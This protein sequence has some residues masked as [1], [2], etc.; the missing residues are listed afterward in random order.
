M[1]TRQK[2]FV[3][4]ILMG[5]AILCL[6]GCGT[7]SPPPLRDRQ[8]AFDAS[9]PPQYP[10]QSSGF[11]GWITNERGETTGGIL[12]SGAVDRY[13]RLVKVYRLQLQEATGVLVGPGDGVQPFVDQYG[14]N[15]FRMDSQHLTY[16]VRLNRWA[17]EGRAEDSIWQKVRSAVP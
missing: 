2:R 9:T 11:L 4:A 1:T 16:F 12:T 6:E 10:A 17:K 13:N 5:C 15:V 8:A 7:V 14:N 3:I